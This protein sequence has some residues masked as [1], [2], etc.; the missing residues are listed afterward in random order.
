MQVLRWLKL[1]DAR[2]PG[3]SSHSLVNT[4]GPKEGY[5]KFAWGWDPDAKVILIAGPPG[6]A[7]NSSLA[8]NKLPIPVLVSLGIGKTTLAHVAVRQAGYRPVEVNAS[9]D[10]SAEGIRT[11]VGNA[12]QISSSM[13]RFLA[14]LSTCHGSLAP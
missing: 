3:R 9:D 10:R 7:E 14:S 11:L 4:F 6:K 1:W 8:G 2:V 13:F 5:K 12:M